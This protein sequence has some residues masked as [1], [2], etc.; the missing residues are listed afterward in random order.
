MPSTSL[1]THTAASLTPELEARLHSALTQYAGIREQIAMLEEVADEEKA[2]MQAILDE[3]GADKTTQ[4]G[5]HVAIV[6]GT[7]SSLDK[8][9]LIALGVSEAMIQQATVIKPKRPY[10][11][12]RKAGENGDG[13]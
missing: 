13:D 7:S 8:K 3:A 10:L 2:K 9:R 6:R 11:S 5:Y 12:V 1:E 4:D